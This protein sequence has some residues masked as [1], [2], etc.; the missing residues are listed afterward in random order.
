MNSSC[1]AS[2]GSNRKLIETVT[3]AGVGLP[4]CLA[5][6]YWY[7]LRAC[8]A[9]SRREAGPEI[10][11]IDFTRPEAS[12]R[13]SRVTMAV[14]LLSK[15]LSELGEA[16]ARTDLISFGGTKEALPEVGAEDA[17]ERLSKERATGCLDIAGEIED[18]CRTA[19]IPAGV[20]LGL[21]AT[22]TDSAE[23]FA[24]SAVVGCDLAGRAAIG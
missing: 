13:A 5:G 23:A 7:C 3:W 18:S 4:C 8:I 21:D 16:I 19:G 6:A 2:Y 15:Y 22:R 14:L 24:A 17:S 10:T 20:F 9:A 12:T 1:R 11:L